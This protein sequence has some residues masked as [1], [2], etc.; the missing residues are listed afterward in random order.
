[1]ARFGRVPGL[2]DESS[3]VYYDT[4]ALVAGTTTYRFFTVPVGGAKSRRL[5]NMS[6]SGQL[7]APQSL[8]I[9]AVRVIPLNA[10]TVQCTDLINRSYVVFKVGEKEQLV[11]PTCLFNG[12]AGVSNRITTD[13]A[14]NGVPDARSI[15]SLEKPVVIGVSQNFYLDLIYDTAPATATAGFSVLVVL[16]GA[17]VRGVQ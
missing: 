11:A 7:P 2:L 14:N 16:D 13:V 6:L 3:Q 5:T 8:K 10:S 17:L 15:W 12:G 1:M 9:N 4:L